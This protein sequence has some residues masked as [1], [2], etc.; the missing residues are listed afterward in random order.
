MK[1]YISFGNKKFQHKKKLWNTE[2]KVLIVA[3]NRKRKTHMP[4][5]S[6]FLDQVWQIFFQHVLLEKRKCDDQNK[7]FISW[8]MNLSNFSLIFI[9]RIYFTTLIS[10][11]LTFFIFIPCFVR[12]FTGHWTFMF[13]NFRIEIFILV[14]FVFLFLWWR[15]FV[16]RCSIGFLFTDLIVLLSFFHLYITVI[17]TKIRIN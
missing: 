13:L 6:S 15:H 5:F 4:S 3:K 10:F 2:M 11:F 17:I 16:S 9:F 14:E 7:P 1:F 8:N 12:W